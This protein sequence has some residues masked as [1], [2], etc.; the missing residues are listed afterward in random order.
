Q[1]IRLALPLG[2]VLRRPAAQKIGDVSAPG[3]FRRQPHDLSDL[4]VP[5]PVS[6]RLKGASS[7]L[8]RGAPLSF[9]SEEKYPSLPPKRGGMLAPASGPSD[10][11]C[12]KEARRYRAPPESP[13][14]DRANDPQ[15]PRML[16]QVKINRTR[17][18]AGISP[19]LR[20]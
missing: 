15:S 19:H 2:G 6:Y 1:R 3:K 11:A 13:F 5:S 18:E 8:L 10:R 17:S 20:R 12:G 7:P 4:H 16:N 14:P 9:Y